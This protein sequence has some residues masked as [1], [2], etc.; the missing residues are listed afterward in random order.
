MPKVED[1]VDASAGAI[2]PRL[3]IERIVKDDGLIL[4]QVLFFVTDAH[5]GTLS[6]QQGQMHSKLLAR[7]PVVRRDVRAW[8]QGREEAVEVV[9]RDDRLQDLDCTGHFGAIFI[10]SYVVKV[11]VEYIPVACVVAIR[12]DLVLRDVVL[13]RVSR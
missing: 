1:Q 4:H 2:V 10:K 5:A 3:M 12:S 7:R 11:Q 8:S 13:V 6:R 9:P